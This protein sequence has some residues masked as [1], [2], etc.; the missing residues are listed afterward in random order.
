VLGGKNEV[1]VKEKDVGRLC[2][3]PR[4][5]PQMVDR[6]VE[7]VLPPLRAQ[8]CVLEVDSYGINDMEVKSPAAGV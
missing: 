7:R 5:V 6:V 3:I 4:N 8:R 2:I 1:D